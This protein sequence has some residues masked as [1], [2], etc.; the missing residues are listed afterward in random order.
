MKVIK[1]LLKPLYVRYSVAKFCCNE[2]QFLIRNLCT[3]NTYGKR[4]KLRY[5]L[6]LQAHIIEKGLSLDEVR[7]GFGVPKIR[8][9][10]SDLD[11]YYNRYKDQKMLFFV[12][13]IVEQYI[14]FHKAHNY[15]V[16]HSIM[17]VFEKLQTLILP[18]SR[19]VFKSYNGG[20]TEIDYPAS[21]GSP[22]QYDS[23]VKLRHSIRS[24]TG[25]PISND[26]ICKALEIAETTPSACNRQ[27]WDIYVRT[28]KEA[29]I[30]ILDIQSGARQFKEKVSALI[31]VGSTAN[32]F[33]ITEGHQPYVNGGLYAMNLMLAF[34]S[35]NVGCIPL[36]MGIDVKKLKRIK[37][38]LRM[39]DDCVPV[40]LLAI[41]KVPD[42][43]RVACSKRFSY[44]DYTH[45]E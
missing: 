44:K 33:S 14:L 34:H 40:I 7:L 1:T 5:S 6:L 39:P 4:E 30:K 3:S 38:E 29:I 22:F 11:E 8:R 24:F 31:M 20:A 26:V 10:L 21:F 25:E 28:N 41:G 23:F 35:L 19:E 2:Y 12:L 37:S 9:L 13:S 32:A 27:P 42:K 17:G 16:D 45:F 15:D 43:I 36:N 18:E